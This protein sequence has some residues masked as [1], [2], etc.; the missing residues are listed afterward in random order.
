MRRLE[1][2]KYQPARDPRKAL[3]VR[4]ERR[5]EKLERVPTRD[6]VAIEDCAARQLHAL[7]VKDRKI[8]PMQDASSIEQS[9]R[10]VQQQNGALGQDRPEEGSP[11]LGIPEAS[12]R[13]S[14][15]TS[16]SLKPCSKR[17]KL[18]SSVRQK[19]A[20]AVTTDKDR[21]SVCSSPMWM[22]SRFARGFARAGRTTRCARIAY[23]RDPR[24]NRRRRERRRA[25]PPCHRSPRRAS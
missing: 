12:R 22:E 14:H 4:S 13:K 9:G 1:K 18:F 20:M 17:G 6:A 5:T 19:S 10:D 24:F 11:T 23:S 2:E 7:L 25:P 21:A 15:C 3:D 16:A 8:G